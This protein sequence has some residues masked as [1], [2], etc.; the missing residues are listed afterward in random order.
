MNDLKKTLCDKKIAPVFYKLLG[1]MIVN[2]NSS[3]LVIYMATRIPG[4][5][6]FVA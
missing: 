3:F 6:F 5:K 1:L 2:I 4:D